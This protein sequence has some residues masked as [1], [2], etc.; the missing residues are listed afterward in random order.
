MT[1]S[2]RYL[3]GEVIDYLQRSIKLKSWAV[4]RV[5]LFFLFAFSLGVESHAIRDILKM[6]SVQQLYMNHHHLEHAIMLVRLMNYNN[7]G[8]RDF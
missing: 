5:A 2:F 1:E 6:I 8:G 7:S 3:T 4:G